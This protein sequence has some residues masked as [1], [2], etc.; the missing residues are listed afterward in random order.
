MGNKGH[1]VGGEEGKGK[2]TVTVMNCGNETSRNLSVYTNALHFYGSTKQELFLSV[3]EG[4][5]LQLHCT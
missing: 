3:L 5:S 4:I 2:H 1:G